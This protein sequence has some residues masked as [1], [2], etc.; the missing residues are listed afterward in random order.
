MEL[1]LLLKNG[2]IWA[3][4]NI[5]LSLIPNSLIL[6]ASFLP[7]DSITA[8]ISGMSG[9]SGLAVGAVW[10]T[11][12]PALAE[13]N[14]KWQVGAVVLTEGTGAVSP[15]PGI[16]PPVQPGEKEVISVYPNPATDYLVVDIQNPIPGIIRTIRV[17]DFA[18]KLCMEEELTTDQTHKVPVNLKPGFYMMHIAEGSVVM[19]TQ[20]LIIVA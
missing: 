2:R 13:Q 19:L 1:R 15:A 3:S 7:E 6:R 20:K 5:L 17:F 8:R 12:D 10:G 11:N 14:G 4:M 9:K 16:P 18:G